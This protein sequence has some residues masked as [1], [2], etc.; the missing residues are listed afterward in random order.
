[1]ICQMVLDS[2]VAGLR[3]GS[4]AQARQKLSFTRQKNGISANRAVSY[5]Y[6][7]L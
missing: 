1:M 5:A 7:I 4:N 6:A 3:K 2:K